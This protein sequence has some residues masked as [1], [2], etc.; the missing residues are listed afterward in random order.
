MR[1]THD[2]NRTSYAQVHRQVKTMITI[3]HLSGNLGFEGAL[4]VLA[5]EFLR[6]W[7]CNTLSNLLISPI[8]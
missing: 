4:A 6:S 7:F 2:R 1:E 8:G 3:F 5:P